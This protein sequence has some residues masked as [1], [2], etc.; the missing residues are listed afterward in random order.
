MKGKCATLIA[1]HVVKQA[2]RT[3]APRDASEIAGLL[4]Q[5]AGKAVDLESCASSPPDDTLERGKWAWGRGKAERQREMFVQHIA[6]LDS[7]G[8]EFRPNDSALGKDLGLRCIRPH[9]GPGQK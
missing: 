5:E 4:P 6:D 3:D 2:R 1:K 8:A 9:D 7:L